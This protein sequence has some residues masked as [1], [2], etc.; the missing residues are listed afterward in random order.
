MDSKN[1]NKDGESHMIRWEKITEISEEV[2]K[3]IEA[4]CDKKK[5][6]QR[7]VTDGIYCEVCVR[8]GGHLSVSHSIESPSEYTCD[9]C[10]WQAWQSPPA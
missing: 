5:Q 3:E 1:S 8:C 10:G 6:I 9:A 7:M 2:K 4:E